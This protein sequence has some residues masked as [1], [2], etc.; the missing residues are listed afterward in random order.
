ME[1]QALQALRQEKAVK[2]VEGLRERIEQTP[3]LELWRWIADEMYE[4]TRDIA[5]ASRLEQEAAQR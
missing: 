1:S 2:L 3:P 4:G 5:R